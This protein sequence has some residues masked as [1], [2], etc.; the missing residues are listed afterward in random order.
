MISYRANI[1]ITDNHRMFAEGLRTML[2]IRKRMGNPRIAV[3]AQQALEMIKSE[4]CDLLITE[5]DIAGKSG[6]ELA[7]VVKKQYPDVKILIVTP[8]EEMSMI[9]D[10]IIA[11]ADGYILKN[12]APEKFFDA[13]DRILEK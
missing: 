9:Q 11:K 7:K 4:K 8:N 5:T 3:T 6:L 2:M 13:I 10:I 12:S 1:V